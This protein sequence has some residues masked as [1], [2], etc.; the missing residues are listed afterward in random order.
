MT[1][2]V[3]VKLGEGF[4]KELSDLAKR[5]PKVIDDIETLITDLE[6]GSKPGDKIAN[7]GHDVYKVRL[8]NRSANKGKSSGFRVIY[9]VRVADEIVLLSIY[10]KSDRTDFDAKRIQQ[11]ITSEIFS[12][13]PDRDA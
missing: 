2:Q 4:S 3:E 12:L 5:F 11:I 9:F 6:S 8:R 7:V 13:P 1:H 10:S